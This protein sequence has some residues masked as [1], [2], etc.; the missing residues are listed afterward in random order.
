M[1]K[2]AKKTSLLS[3]LFLFL[4]LIG[5]VYLMDVLNR[6]VNVLTY[7]EFKTS[8]SKGEITEVTIVPRTGASVYEISGKKEGYAENESFFIKVPYSE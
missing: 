8:L 3:Y 7:D 5:I 6:K 4:F 2:K 1:N